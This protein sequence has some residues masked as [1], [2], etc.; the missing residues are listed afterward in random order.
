MAAG[1]NRKRRPAGRRQPTQQDRLVQLWSRLTSTSTPPAMDRW[2]GRELSRLDGLPRADRL[3][4]GDLLVDAVRFAPLTVFCEDWRRGGWSNGDD[5]ARIL[6]AHARLSGPEVWSSLG[7]LPAAAV[8]FWTFMR[9][10]QEGADLPSIAPPGPDALEVW[11]TVKQWAPK[12]SEPAVRAL[13]AGVPPDLVDHLEDRAQLSGWSLQQQTGFLDR[14]AT[15]PP[16]WLR[17]T[18]AARITDLAAE[19]T[20]AGFT[21][22]QEGGA[23]GLTGPL[24]VYELDCYREGRVDIQDL[25]SQGIG[26]AVD[27][28]PGQ[29]VW[30]CCA[31]AGGKSLQLAAALGGRGAIH[32]TDLYETKL[33]DLRR[34]ARRAG[35]ANVR[36]AVWDGHTPPDFGREITTRGGFDRVLVDAPCSGSGTWRRNPDGRLRFA[37][38]QLEPLAR[39][40]AELLAIVAPAVVP[41]GLLVYATCSWFR[42]ENEDVVARF[43]AAAS[44]FRLRS[45]GVMGNPEADADT[46]FAAV[47]ERE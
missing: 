32:A 9:K 18:D 22:Q 28:V 13:W 36:T 5:P 26:R 24:G 34:R 2:L 47:M 23:L 16:V 17:P 38:S 37:D 21:V 8:F 27:P 40:Q 46:T 10:R 6:A 41:G 43:L 29:M 12:A 14:H 33:E 15:R 25:A 31:G 42:A 20:T 7:R 39:V 30:D 19:C 45:Q 11:R 35:V 1:K 4:L 44:G 3:M